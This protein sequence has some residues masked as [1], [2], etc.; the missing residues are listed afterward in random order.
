MAKYSLE[1]DT[2]L[3][4]IELKDVSG[5][6]LGSFEF[7]PTDSDIVNRYKDVVKAFNE[8]EAPA[9]LFSEDADEEET[10]SFQI[11]FSN[12][13]REQFDYLLAHKVSDRI[14][15]TCGPLTLL[16]NGDFFFEHVIE[17]LGDLIAKIVEK[18][19]DVKLEKIRSAVA[20]YENE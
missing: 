13:I 6:V 16:E 7:S 20:K 8:V 17:G 11:Y 15:A 10:D 1:V 19:I 2:G 18:R 9:S 5:K 4:E 14:F 12:L 3:V